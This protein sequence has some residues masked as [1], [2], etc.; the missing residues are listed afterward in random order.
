M[1]LN[2][3]QLKPQK[4]NKCLNQGSELGGRSNDGAFQSWSGGCLMSHLL[5]NKESFAAFWNNSFHFKIA[6]KVYFKKIL[7]S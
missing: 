1:Y 5:V 3:P 2:Q 4:S 6:A 7:P